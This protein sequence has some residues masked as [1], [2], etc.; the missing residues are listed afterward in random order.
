MISD[1]SQTTLDIKS[2]KSKLQ[3]QGFVLIKDLGFNFDY[4]SFLCQWGNLM[5]Q[6]DN[7]LT[8]DVKVNPE[9]ANA[10]CSLGAVKVAPH[11]EYYEGNSD[12]PNYLA[13]WCV[14]PASCGGGKIAFAD[15]YSFLNSLSS[16]EKNYLYNA[17][18]LY[19]AEIGLSKF[20]KKFNYNPCAYHSIL[21]KSPFG[22]DIFRFNTTGMES[23]DMKFLTTF[24]KRFLNF[25]NQNC[26]ELYQPQNSLLIWDNYRMVH[27]RS[28]R[29]KDIK[30]HLI[31]FWIRENVSY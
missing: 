1:N 27:S 9:I 14:H 23:G 15:G 19:K 26:T 16:E 29:F 7:E 25:Y 21:S 6:Y 22:K 20:L 31:R 8:W 3:E 12:P 17:V 11:T 30:R 24:R 2:Y 13:L 4:Y 18:Y 28:T 5:P 10:E